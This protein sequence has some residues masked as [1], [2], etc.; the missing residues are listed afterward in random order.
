MPQSGAPTKRLTRNRPIRSGHERF[1]IAACIFLL[2]AG[3]EPLFFV[4]IYNGAARR[5]AI[6]ADAGGAGRIEVEAF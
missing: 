2:L 3:C 5:A 6:A 4:V 1:R